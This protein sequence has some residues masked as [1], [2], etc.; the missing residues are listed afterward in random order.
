MSFPTYGV[1][2]FR[3]KDPTDGR[4]DVL[5]GVGCSDMVVLHPDT[6]DIT[7]KH[8]IHALDFKI[9]GSS[10]LLTWRVEAK[11]RQLEIENVDDIRTFV[12]LIN[13]YRTLTKNQK[14]QKDQENVSSSSKAPKGRPLAPVSGSQASPDR[15]GPLSGSSPVSPSPRPASRPTSRPASPTPLS[16][17]AGDRK[18]I[19][20]RPTQSLTPIEIM[21]VE[22]KEKKRFS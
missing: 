7:S 21:K 17:P 14:N 20:G 10:R 4:K 15:V 5:I 12:D 11:E 18:G 16:M 2:T 13:G 9:D 19:S 8:S 1:T 3:A 6:K 22:Q